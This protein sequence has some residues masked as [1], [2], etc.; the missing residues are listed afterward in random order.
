M[1]AG[2]MVKVLNDEAKREAATF[3]EVVDAHSRLAFRVAYAVLRNHEDAEDA[4]QETF[5]RVYKARDKD[6]QDWAAWVARIAY[7]VAIDH[8][9]SR[10]HVDMEEIDVA[11]GRESHLE[12]LSREQQVAKLRRLIDTLPEDLRHA[13]MLSELQELNS[14]QV[15][16]AL[17]IPDGTVRT[18]LM[19][20]RQMLREKFEGGR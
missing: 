17:G 14:R 4:V 2:A 15:A 18:R 19:K 1:L 5:L 3:E 20:A 6:V 8:V 13:L 12:V 7:R 11:D 10:K 9:R 16:E